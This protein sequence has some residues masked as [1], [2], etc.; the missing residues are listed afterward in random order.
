MLFFTDKKN[1]G[2]KT[3]TQRQSSPWKQ[4]KSLHPPQNPNPKRVSSADLSR[5][6]SQEQK[7]DYDK[8]FQK[9]HKHF[10]KNLCNISNATLKDS[11][12]RKFLTPSRS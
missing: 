2:A 4:G 8:T 10:E 12:I 5:Y 3:H 11:T 7:V 9:V 6:D 1:T